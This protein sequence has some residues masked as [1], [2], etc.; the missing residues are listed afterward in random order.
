MATATTEVVEIDQDEAFNSSSDE[1]VSFNEK[2][3]NLRAAT[4]TDSKLLRKSL[5]TCPAEFNEEKLEGLMHHYQNNKSKSR[6]IEGLLFVLRQLL[7]PVPISAIPASRAWGFLTMDDAFGIFNSF[8]DREVGKD[9]FQ[10][11]LLHP[12]YGLRVYVAQI[13]GT[14]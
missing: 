9:E 4:K 1:N 6:I 5:Q 14:R 8:F 3:G 7:A 13:H 11:H 10:D 2:R 12:E